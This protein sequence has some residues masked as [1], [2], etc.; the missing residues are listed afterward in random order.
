[1]IIPKLIAAIAIFII[2]ADMLIL[3]SLPDMSRFAM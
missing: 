3:S 1:M 2:G